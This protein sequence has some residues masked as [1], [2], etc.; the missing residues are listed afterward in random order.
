MLLCHTDGS[1]AGPSTPPQPASNPFASQRP[2]SRGWGGGT[3]DCRRD[4]GGSLDLRLNLFKD[5]E[6]VEWA[7]LR[8]HLTSASDFL[9]P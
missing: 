3:D 8:P 2:R 1:V 9:F 4:A 6:I 7:P 5:V